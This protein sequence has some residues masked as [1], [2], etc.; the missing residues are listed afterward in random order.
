MQAGQHI[1]RNRLEYLLL[2]ALVARRWLIDKPLQQKQG[3]G[4]ERTY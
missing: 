2:T 4:D 3:S 1:G